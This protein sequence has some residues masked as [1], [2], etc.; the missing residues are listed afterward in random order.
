MASH[1]Q[2]QMP[3]LRRQAQ[4]PWIFRQALLVPEAV[5]LLLI[6]G[7][8]WLTSGAPLIAFIG[9][10]VI[11]FFGI[12]FALLVAARHALAEARYQQAQRLITVLLRLYPWSADSLALRGM[13]LLA[14][15]KAD[16]A[17]AVLR[18]ALQLF[19]GQA[20]IHVLLSS[21]LLEL[22]RFI[23][24]RWEGVQAL[25]LDP[26]C[27]IAYLYVAQAEQRLGVPSTDVEQRLREG[28]ALPCDPATEGALR[29]SLALVLCSLNQDGEARL[30]TAGIES[31]LNRCSALE[32]ASLLY[33]L[34][35]LRHAQGEIEQARML[36]RTCEQLDPHGRYAA[37]AWRAARL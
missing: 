29:C 32:R 2:E 8:Y 33:H 7:L 1:L 21:T 12:R 14:T 17:E 26:S 23:E 19:P 3:L 28:L 24:A 35:Q 36:F 18:K 30:A 27:A 15:N 31:L 20:S 22:E 16:Q 5:A 37:A 11:V 25:T 9:L 6:L 13:L 10:G 4:L 34:G